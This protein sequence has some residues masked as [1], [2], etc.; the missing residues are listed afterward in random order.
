MTTP[1]GQKVPH[2]APHAQ[3]LEHRSELRKARLQEI[4]PRT[5]QVIAAPP[6]ESVPEGHRMRITIDGNQATSTAEPRIDRPSVSPT[7]KSGIQVTSAWIKVEGLDRCLKQ[8]R[9]V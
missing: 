2:R 5:W 7:A 6:C 8:D 3:G 4:K 9:L 1:P